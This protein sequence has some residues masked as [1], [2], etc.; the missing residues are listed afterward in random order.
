VHVHHD[1]HVATCVDVTTE[2]QTPRTHLESTTMKKL[3]TLLA[4]STLAAFGVLFSTAA[5]DDGSNIEDCEADADCSVAGDVCIDLQCLAPTCADDADCDLADKDSP[6]V[7]SDCEADAD[8]AAA[9]GEVC[10]NDG[11][12]NP[13][14]VLADSDDAGQ[15]CEELGA[16]VVATIDGAAVCV[17]DS[18]QS[19][20]GQCVDG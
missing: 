14:C 6:S 13:F 16:F 4:V 8:C 1:C 19:C 15:G 11:V 10:V 12:G 17:S 2:A 5:C 18:G 7:A 9:D 20:E 3:S